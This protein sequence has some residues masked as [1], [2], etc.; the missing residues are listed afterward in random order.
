MLDGLIKL[1]MAVKDHN[2]TNK[3]TCK[4]RFNKRKRCTEHK[5]MLPS[6]PNYCCRTN[7]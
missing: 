5:V 1:G 2:I 4:W 6:K 7:V 3:R